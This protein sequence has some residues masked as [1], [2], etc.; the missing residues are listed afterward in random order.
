[1]GESAPLTV[2]ATALFLESTAQLGFVLEIGASFGPTTVGAIAGG[3][4]GGS[5]RLLASIEVLH[6]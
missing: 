3:L 1:M 2:G 4:P 6:D 5:G